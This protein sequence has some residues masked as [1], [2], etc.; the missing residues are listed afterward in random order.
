MHPP[1]RIAILECDEPIGQTKEKYGSYG[2]LFRELLENGAG[3]IAASQDGDGDGAPALDITKFDVVKHEVYPD[4]DG[5]DAVLLTGSRTYFILFFSL[6]LS[7]SLSIHPSSHF[8]S[9]NQSIN[10]S[11]KILT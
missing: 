11:I 8:Q 1:L 6:S 4:L 5:V 2:N 7:L 3:R 10:Q 9:I